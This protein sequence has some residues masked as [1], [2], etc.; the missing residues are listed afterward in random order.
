MQLIVPT[1]DPDY[2]L[3]M[4]FRKDGRNITEVPCKVWLPQSPVERGILQFFSRD[5]G[6]SALFHS[7]YDLAGSIL[8]FDKKPQ[9]SI[10]AEEFYVNGPTTTYKSGDEPPHVS[11]F[12]YAEKLIVTRPLYSRD[13]DR[14]GR[15]H[16]RFDLTPNR[17]LNPFQSVISSYT[18]NHKVQTHR[19]ISL[20]VP[21]LG[22]VRFTKYYRI[23]TKVVPRATTLIPNLTA[24][25]QLERPA[26]D[27]I[28]LDSEIRDA[29]GVA[30]LL[31]SFA[32][33]QRTVAPAWHAVDGTHI[34]DCFAG[35]LAIPKIDERAGVYDALIDPR[36]FPNFLRVSV[37]RFTKLEKYAQTLLRE[38]LY[39]ALPMSDET[40]ESRFL[41]MFS[42]L[43]SLV[44]WFRK[45]NNYEYT[46]P[47][48]A[49]WRR[50][51][52]DIAA[53]VTKHE[54]L[55]LGA[56]KEMVLEMV[57]A[58]RRVPLKRAFQ[59][60]CEKFK[61]ETSDL[62]PAFD[63][64]GSL[65]A[66]RN[67]LSHGDSFRRSSFGALV[68]A[69]ANLEIIVERMILA[70]LGWP[71]KRSHASPQVLKQMGWKPGMDLEKNMEILARDLR[72]SADQ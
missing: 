8:G 41:S 38:A 4:Q 70:A 37:R 31:A 39:K 19:K 71:A 72:T 61:L 7:P 52:S 56:R 21:S 47:S 51:R 18:G 9:V 6:H 28:A 40:T 69:N 15:T 25:L 5:E 44:L 12:G 24:E 64:N 22:Q 16:L 66:I 35:N 58:L 29:L 14:A 42:A 46:I 36:N 45:R 57:G 55:H 65:N 62:W 48:D 63:S 11:G 60:F 17:L 49:N 27:L 26:Q 2:E 30:L 33:R 53:L 23:D 34:V 68:W 43:E 67:R 59:A 20:R 10:K 50:F 3:P 32:A 13:S 1:R 54:S